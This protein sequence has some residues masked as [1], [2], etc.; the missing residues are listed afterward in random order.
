MDPDYRNEIEEI[1][2]VPLSSLNIDDLAEDIRNETDLIASHWGVIG[3][4]RMILKF[5][6]SLIQPILDRK[7]VPVLVRMCRRDD[8]PQL[9]REAS[10]VLSNMTSG[11]EEQVS[12][13][14]DYNAEVAFLSILDRQES[15][16]VEQGIIGLSNLVMLGGAVRTRL[17]SKGLLDRL[18]KLNVNV[19]KN[20]FRVYLI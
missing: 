17:L 12:E 11:A 1:F 20:S 5:E 9:K 3:L 18:W 2:R 7:L 8:R 6:Q 19:L 4:R 16:M 10:W 14:L 15:Y 13:L